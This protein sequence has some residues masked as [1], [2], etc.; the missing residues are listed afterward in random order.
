MH[1]HNPSIESHSHD[2]ADLT[3]GGGGLGFQAQQAQP[4]WRVRALNEQGG[5]VFSAIVT[6][7]EVADAMQF[8][9]QGLYNN[10]FVDYDNDWV[11]GPVAKL[12]IEKVLG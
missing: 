4:R 10:Q 5:T 11:P 8:A 12:T 1:N 7:P 3:A 9:A 6:V 2:D